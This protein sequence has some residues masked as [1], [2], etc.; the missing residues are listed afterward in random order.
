[1]LELAL[2]EYHKLTVF[3]VWGTVCVKDLEVSLC[4][5]SLETNAQPPFPNGKSECKMFFC[6]EDLCNNDTLAERQGYPNSAYSP[7]STTTVAS[8]L[9]M[10][11][12]M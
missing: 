1:M 5:I 11:Y 6:D 7:F 12:Y 4:K 9:I 3:S 8:I 10:M 2:S